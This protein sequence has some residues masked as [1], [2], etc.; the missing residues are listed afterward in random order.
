MTN[1]S[2]GPV[3]TPGAW[4][5]ED[6]VLAN[7]KM[8]M[9]KQMFFEPLEVAKLLAMTACLLSVTVIASV[10]SNGKRPGYGD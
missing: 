3:R 7:P 4:V 9:E 6:L 1:Q 5:E 8:G 10:V 2:E